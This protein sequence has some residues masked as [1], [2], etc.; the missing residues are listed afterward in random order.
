LTEASDNSETNEA[1]AAAAQN[2][3][4]RSST[5]KV[6]LE[7]DKCAGHAQCHAVNPDLFP[8]DDD[9]PRSP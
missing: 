9:D 6:W 1:G 8:I 2:Q 7:R 5:M 3:V 4:R